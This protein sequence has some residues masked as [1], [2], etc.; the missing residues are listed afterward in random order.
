MALKECLDN[1]LPG[2]VAVNRVSV[3]LGKGSP[4]SGHSQRVSGTQE[5]VT[6]TLVRVTNPAA[7]SLLVLTGSPVARVGRGV[8]CRKRK[9][10]SL[11]LR[12]PKGGK[13]CFGSQCPFGLN[14][15]TLKRPSLTWFTPMLGPRAPGG[16]KFQ[17]TTSASTCQLENTPVG[18]NHQSAVQV[19]S[20]LLRP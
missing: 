11:P 17:R 12:F 10:P 4:T 7:S 1:Y 19:T 9:R 8:P 2:F 5:G 14:P 20:L 15:P 16:T 18:Q 6:G 13:V 3:L